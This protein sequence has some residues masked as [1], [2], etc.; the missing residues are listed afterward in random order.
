MVSRQCIYFNYLFIF[1]TEE[2]QERTLSWSVD[3]LS[4]DTLPL[5]AGPGTTGDTNVIMVMVVFVFLSLR[6]CPCLGETS[7][8]CT[9]WG[10]S[11]VEK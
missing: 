2:L 1:T 11:A 8:G 4:A 7:K 6:G 3:P 9:H 5:S 10:G